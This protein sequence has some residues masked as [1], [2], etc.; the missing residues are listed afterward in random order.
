MGVSGMDE[1]MIDLKVLWTEL[2]CFR[3][4]K[5]LSATTVPMLPHVLVV[6]PLEM[7]RG[8]RYTMA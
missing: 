2:K 5:V 1:D 3:Q 6:P 8:T 7:A 4:E